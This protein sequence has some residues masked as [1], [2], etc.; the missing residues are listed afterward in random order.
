VTGQGG[1]GGRFGL[2]LGGEPY[3]GVFVW[4]TH[5]EFGFVWLR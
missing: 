4:L 5:V 3:A 2:G 1:Y